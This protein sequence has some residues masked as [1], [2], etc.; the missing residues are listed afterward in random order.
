VAKR[1]FLFAL[2]VLS[3][4]PLLAMLFDVKFAVGLRKE[5]R[6]LA[7]F[8]DLR[9]SAV[10]D[11]T[12]FTQLDNYFNDHFGFRDWVIQSKQTF[13]QLAFNRVR[14]DLVLGKDNSVYYKFI[15]E[16]YVPEL[17][18]T[19]PTELM[20]E[21]FTKLNERLAARGIRLAIVSF[22][23]NPLIYPEKLAEYWGVEHDLDK[24]PFYQGFERLRRQGIPV[25][26]LAH[27]FLALKEQ[28]LVFTEVEENHCTPAAL[29]VALRR[30]LA[31][32]GEMADVPV[33]LPDDFPKTYSE[34]IYGGMGY[35]NAHRVNTNYGSRPAWAWEKPDGVGGSRQYY[36]NPKGVLPST[37]IYTDSFA[38]I[39]AAEFGPA[40]LPHFQELEL[41]H[42]VF[43]P[44]SITPRTRIVL[45]AVSDQAI[46]SHVHYYRRLLEKLAGSK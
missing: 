18:R 21:T 30:I 26:I 33:A 2:L 22:P 28:E 4:V 8:P 14:P 25:L 3:F 11:A 6:F 32:L 44:E 7:P 43:S 39:L 36:A 46:E 1:I 9:W 45:V 12:Y 34:R 40:F 15:V 24:I 37:T 23:N 38:H 41:D 42:G 5:N 19:F 17:Y 31:M 16:R 35:R 27:D 13:D 20:V 29:F 10:R